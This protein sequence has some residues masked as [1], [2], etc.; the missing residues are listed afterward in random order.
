MMSGAVAGLAGKL[1]VLP[2]D[3]LKKRLQVRE[4]DTYA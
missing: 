1:A 3:V 2:L 4:K